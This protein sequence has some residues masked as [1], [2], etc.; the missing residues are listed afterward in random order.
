MSSS[1]ILPLDRFN[2]RVQCEYISGTIL[3]VS[4]PRTP[5]EMWPFG[6]RSIAPDD[7]KRVDLLEER[8]ESLTRR[9]AALMEDLDEFYSKVNK[10]RQ[11][12]V[13]EDRDALRLGGDAP[14]SAAMAKARLRA[15]LLRSARG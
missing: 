7:L 4:V 15:T 1:E 14:E 10:A 13:K 11:R 3:A 9:M 12:V 5:R 2:Y 8:T 6:H